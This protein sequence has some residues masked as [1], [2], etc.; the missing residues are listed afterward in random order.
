VVG[1]SKLV[2]DQD[3]V[4]R[5]I[6][7]EHISRERPNRDFDPLDLKLEADRLGKPA[8]VLFVALPVRR[9]SAP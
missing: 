8:N 5:C 7:R 1:F 6:L 4:S 3:V 2:L 9:P